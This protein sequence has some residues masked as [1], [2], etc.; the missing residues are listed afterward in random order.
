MDD[1]KKLPLEYSANHLYYR[2]VQR[3]EKLAMYAVCLDAED[4]RITGYEIFEIKT[5]QPRER[6][7]DGKTFKTFWKEAFPGNEDFGVF[8]FS[9]LTREQ[10]EN[11]FT[12]MCLNIKIPRGVPPYLKSDIEY[13]SESKIGVDAKRS[14]AVF[15]PKTNVLTPASSDKSWRLR[16]YA[17]IKG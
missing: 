17:G 3:N 7:I 16:V 10:A 6:T 11:S 14:K 12:K 13:H 15:M 2:Q 4:K 8:A 1:L 5:R 9:W